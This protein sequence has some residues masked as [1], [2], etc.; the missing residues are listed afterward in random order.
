MKIQDIF[1]KALVDLDSVSLPGVNLLGNSG[2]RE[3]PGAGK[4]FGD[5]DTRKIPG[6]GDTYGNLTGMD[7]TKTPF[8]LNKRYKKVRAKINKTKDRIAKGKMH[9]KIAKAA[10]K[11]YLQTKNPKYIK[12]MRKNLQLARKV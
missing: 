9:L 8:K 10:Q 4:T 5:L 6:G 2:V 7:D 11:K 12:I 3:I 1:D